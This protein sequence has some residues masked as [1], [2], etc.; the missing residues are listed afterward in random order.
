MCWPALLRCQL[1]TYWVNSIAGL[2]CIIP[3]TILHW[4]WIQTLDCE[5]LAKVHNGANIQGTK[6]EPSHFDVLVW[7]FPGL[8]QVSE[9]GFPRYTL[10]WV[11]ETNYWKSVEL[12]PEGT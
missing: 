3:T 1:G 12:G 5:M 6:Q 4:L 7:C 2:H 8:K 10:A 9:T 11:F